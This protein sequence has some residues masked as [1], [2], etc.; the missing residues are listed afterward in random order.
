MLNDFQSINVFTLTTGDIFVNILVAFL[1]GLFISFLYKVTYRGPGFSISFV[2]SI[3][4]LS[5]ITAV[6]IMVIG[7]N[8]ARA[9]GLVGAMSIIRFRTAVKE[10]QDIVFIFF[11]L[12]IGMAAG[13]GY[14]KMAIIGTLIIGLIIF[15]FSKSKISGVKQEE[16]LL[17]FMF[18]GTN[19]DKVP[20]Y[21]SVL[22]KY[23]QKTKIINLKSVGEDDQLELS[24]Y[25]KLKD[26]KQSDRFIKDL[27]SVEGVDY[28]NLFFDEERF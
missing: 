14:H 26:K 28:V 24:Y 1:C 11:G 20:P 22:K 10:T 21:N 18:T 27:S 8:L 19:G 23:C 6:V 3:I 25:V 7:N 16:Y 4:L 13:V 17:Q 9:F 5:M 15:I 12:A 2:N